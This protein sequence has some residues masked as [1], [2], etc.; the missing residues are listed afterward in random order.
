MRIG[1]DLGGTKIEGVVLDEQ[2]TTL[3]RLRLPTP[4]ADYSATLNT[5]AAL[6][7]QLEQECSRSNKTLTVGLA[8]PGSISLLNGRM[9]NCN[10]TCLNGK[11]FKQDL[12]RLLQRD[13]RIANDADCFAL[14]EA[15][16]GQAH[17]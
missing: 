6:V 7:A 14:S 13:I 10:S 12:E 9:K 16:Q 1:I 4:Q 5:I 17:L 2:G 15:Q 3:K 8:T 11:P